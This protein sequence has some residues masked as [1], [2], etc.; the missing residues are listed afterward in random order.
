M[1]SLNSSIL[2]KT[3]GEIAL[4]MCNGCHKVCYCSIACQKKGWK[5][6]KKKCRFKIDDC[7]LEY[8]EVID[9]VCKKR[10]KPKF[11]KDESRYISILTNEKKSDYA[12][13]K[14]IGKGSFGIVFTVEKDGKKF[15]MKTGMKIQ[16]EQFFPQSIFNELSTRFL[17]HPNV[18]SMCRILIEPSN[19]SSPDIYEDVSMIYELAYANL[20]KYTREEFPRSDHPYYGAYDYDDFAIIAFQVVN[21]VAY[22]Y[23]RLTHNADLKSDNFLIGGNEYRDENGE[24][25]IVPHVMLS[26]FG[27]SNTLCTHTRGYFGEGGTYSYMSPEKLL[28]DSIN[29]N[30]ND[31]WACGVILYELATGG[32]LTITKIPS[33]LVK[34]LFFLF[35]FPTEKTWPGV[36]KLPYWRREYENKREDLTQ[37][38]FIREKMGFID[39]RGSFPNL[40]LG[41]LTLNPNKRITIYDALNHPFFTKDKLKDQSIARTPAEYVY[42]TI[43]GSKIIVDKHPNFMFDKVPLPPEYL[44]SVYREIEYPEILYDIKK[45]EQWHSV[46]YKTA[47]IFLASIENVEKYHVER[48]HKDQNKNVEFIETY[49]LELMFTGLSIFRWII[50]AIQ[51]YTQPYKVFLPYNL[52][53]II[54]SLATTRNKY[55]SDFIYPRSMYVQEFK[56][57]SIKEYAMLQKLILRLCDIDVV[58]PNVLDFLRQYFEINKDV[59]EKEDK[60]RKDIVYIFALI[61]LIDILMNMNFNEE[62]IVRKCISAGYY[63]NKNIKDDVGP[64]IL[65]KKVILFF[66]KSIPNFLK[67]KILLDENIDRRRIPLLDKNTQN[68]EKFVNDTFNLRWF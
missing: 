34:N 3:C 35:G 28:G 48:L 65:D 46:Y 16:D 53:G 4:F 5:K 59:I 51:Q 7:G 50:N 66:H 56:F 68:L 33:E 11:K 31:V 9:H 42:K 40:L 54:Y 57:S 23:S 14:L 64:I 18:M 25:H 49:K 1:L 45:N 43:P 67:S 61:M 52:A 36:T 21:A 27:I 47:I 29:T 37:P 13:I 10:W 44:L 30:K 38:S 39:N 62:M 12:V 17:D 8:L 19:P 26:D 58:R 6:H 60:S 32:T 41:M 63:D 55:C 20:R 22:C 15:A 2:C 24:I